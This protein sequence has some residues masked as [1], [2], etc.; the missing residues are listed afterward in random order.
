[1][2]LLAKG[3]LQKIFRRESRSACPCRLSGRKIYHLDRITQEGFNKLQSANFVLGMV[4][5]QDNIYENPE[6]EIKHLTR[7][8]KTKKSVRKSNAMIIDEYG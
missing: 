3:A 5:Q 8:D 6:T 7:I 4:A 2:P 1:M